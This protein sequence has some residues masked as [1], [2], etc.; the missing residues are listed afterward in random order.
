MYNYTMIY[1]GCNCKIKL[2]I[3]SDEIS[4]LLDNN[5][6]DEKHTPYFS[7]LLGNVSE[8]ILSLEALEHAL[9]K[10]I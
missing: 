5:K 2:Q 6:I 3:L 10:D 7:A 8:M 1:D 4:I 9:Q